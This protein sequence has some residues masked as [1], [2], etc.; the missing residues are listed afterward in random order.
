MPLNIKNRFGNISLGNYAGVLAI[1]ESFG[2]CRAGILTGKTTFNLLLASLFVTSLRDAAIGGHG[3]GII[4]ID[5]IAGN[6]DC[7]LSAGKQL[8]AGFAVGSYRFMLKSDN[9]KLLNFRLPPNFD[10]V[11]TVHGIFST[12]E[13][14]SAFLLKPAPPPD[15]STTSPVYADTASHQQKEGRKSLMAGKLKLEADLIKKSINYYGLAGHGK[16]VLNIATSLSK[17]TFY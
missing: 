12:V 9:I 6:V 14:K 1:D 11:V 7:G 16:A 10:A 15:N 8:D 4:K 2:T 17:L 5:T 13:N 3:F